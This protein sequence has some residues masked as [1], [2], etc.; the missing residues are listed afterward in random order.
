[1]TTYSS[2]RN[3]VENLRKAT[4]RVTP[5]QVKL[6]AFAG[7]ELPKTLPQLVAAARLKLALANELSLP[8]TTPAGNGQLEF[9]ESLNKAKARDPNVHADHEEARAW[10]EFYLL[11]RRLKAL[12]QL[13]IEAGDIVE[14]KD[15]SGN[16]V[17]EVVSI[18]DNGRVNFRGGQGARA[19]PDRITLKHKKGAN[20][21]NARKLRQ[22]A[23]NLASTRARMNTW[24][25]AREE[26]LADFKI[27]DPI[28]LDDIEHLQDVIDGAKD[29]RPIQAFLE[30]RPQI[31]VSLL[32]GGSRFSVPRP[33]LAGKHVPDFLLS[34]VDSLG[35][36]WLLVELETPL[37]AVTL[38][39]DTMLDQYAR[40]GLSQI[41]EW[42]NWIQE[43]LE[44]A[45]RS[46]R[47]GG[48]GLIDIRP[49]SEGLVLVGRRARLNGNSDV[50]RHPIREDQRIRVHTYDWLIDRLRGVMKYSGP[51]GTNPYLIQPLR[52]D[53]NE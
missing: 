23:A 34:D 26:E 47:K 13:C 24:S 32:T 51:S 25:M 16:R 43:N 21:S 29:E 1:M 30:A 40:K 5:E 2:W 19:W 4:Q 53:D 45:R 31:L 15:S 52:D 11:E 8:R 14:V 12:E 22:V 49:K 3:P 9:L 27:E 7:I 39:N 28:A 10:I 50:V 44:L 35:I 6:A 42:R 38:K 41:E 18:S 36:R 20:S 37:S 17:E 46:R 33:Q 48:M